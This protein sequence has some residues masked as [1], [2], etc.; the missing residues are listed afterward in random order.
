[1]IAIVVFVTVNRVLRYSVDQADAIGRLDRAVVGIV[2]FV[3]DWT[4]VTQA[5]FAS[6]SLDAW[7]GTSPFFF[8]GVR[9]GKWARRAR[10]RPGG[11]R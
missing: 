2:V 11:P 1:M 4:A 7:D 10:L 9:W 8:Q 6:I 3:I 5:S